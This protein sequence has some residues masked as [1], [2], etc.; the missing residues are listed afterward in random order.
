MSN[1][2]FTVKPLF[3]EPY[4]VTNI[5]DAIS[6]DQI[7]FIKSTLDLSNFLWLENNMPV[8]LNQEIV[9]DTLTIE[10]VDLALKTPNIVTDTFDIKEH[11]KLK[12]LSYKVN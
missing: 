8:E 12:A 6:V 7:K 3:A 9:P 11:P 1:R 2:D 10:N 4:F 5:A